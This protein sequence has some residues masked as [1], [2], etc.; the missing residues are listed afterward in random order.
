MAAE[1]ESAGS[2]TAVKY[3][4]GATARDVQYRPDGNSGIRGCSLI[5]IRRHLERI[6]C[7]IRARSNLPE[8]RETPGSTPDPGVSASDV[9]QTS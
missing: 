6:S 7:G 9:D 5:G 4:N 3:G 2:R 1:S 8:K